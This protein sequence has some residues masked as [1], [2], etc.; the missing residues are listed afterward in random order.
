MELKFRVKCLIFPN[1]VYSESHYNFCDF[2]SSID[3][4]Y[5]SEDWDI[6]LEQEINGEWVPV[7]VTWKK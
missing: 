3:N 1:W 4:Q 6:E 2:W 7:D 5:F